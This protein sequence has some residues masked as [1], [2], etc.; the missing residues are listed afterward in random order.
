MIERDWLGREGKEVVGEG[1]KGIGKGFADRDK[2]C[3]YSK[4]EG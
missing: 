4:E 3:I 1:G 2:I